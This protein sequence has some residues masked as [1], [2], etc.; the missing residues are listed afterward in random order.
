M[1]RKVLIAGESW[2]SFTTHVK[3]ADTFQTSVYEEGVA[4]LREAVEGA[5]FEVVYVPNHH[6]QDRL[7]F[8][9]DEYGEY[10]AV[11]LSDI[12]SNTLLLPSATFAKSAKRPNRCAAIRDYV[13]NGGALIMI[14]GYMSFSGIDGKA[15]YGA[16]ALAEVLPVSCLPVDDR[17]EHSE[18]IAPR[19][20][21]GHPLVEGIDGAWPCLLGYNKTEAKP[22]GEVVV[23]ID[24]DPLI[25]AGDFGRG[26]S[27]VFTSDCSPHWAPPEF[28]SWKHYRTIWENMLNYVV[29]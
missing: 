17:R 9:A 5:G 22:E 23:E 11:I 12:G 28:I 21:K 27:A 10:A 26:R 15:R 16:T 2:T 7:P 18:G 29:R 13:G 24:G 25:A 6:A 19:V 8:T 4:W 20:V 1:A 3:G 14:G